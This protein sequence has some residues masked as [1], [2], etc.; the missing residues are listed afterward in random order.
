MI[1]AP[2]V[3]ALLRFV[4]AL[5]VLEVGS[6]AYGRAVNDRHD[7]R[8]GGELV[9]IDFVFLKRIDRDGNFRVLPRFVEFGGLGEGCE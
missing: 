2:F 1:S 5:G 8:V 4:A 7:A 6:I 3:A 9:P